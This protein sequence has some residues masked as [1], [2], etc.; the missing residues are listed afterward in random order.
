MQ[1]RGDY[2][3]TVPLESSPESPQPLRRVAHLVR[4]WIERLGPVWVEAQLIEI[5][6]RSGSKLIF[7]TLRDKLAEVS[8]SV[9][10]SPTTLDAAGPLTE[11]ATVVARLKPSYYETSGRL[12]FACD[13]DQP[14]R[15]GP[16]AGPAGAD[17]A[18]AAGRGPVR[19]G[20]EEVRCRS[21]P[22][23]SA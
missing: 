17:Q 1:A 14:R 21:C 19:P 4:G 23:R 5:N 12:T 18:A 7:L 10:I 16:A 20:A 6:R 13:A 22:A 2:A 15:R 11:G 3:H 9:T 8:V